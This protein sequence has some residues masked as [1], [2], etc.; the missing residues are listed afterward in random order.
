VLVSNVPFQFSHPHPHRVGYSTTAWDMKG[1]PQTAAV[2]QVQLGDFGPI[3]PLQP[4]WTRFPLDLA[5]AKRVRDHPAFGAPQPRLFL[6]LTIPHQPHNYAVFAW[7]GRRA[8]Q[9][10]RH[11]ASQIVASLQFQI[12]RITLTPEQAPVGALVS[13]Q[14]SGFLGDWRDLAREGGFGITLLDK[15]GDGCDTSI[16]AEFEAISRTR[17]HIDDGG[18][19]TGTF[20]VPAGGHCTAATPTSN[21]SPTVS[22]GSYSVLLGCYQCDF[23]RFSVSGGSG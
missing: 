9:A 5:D 2:V 20:T 16:G 17:L 7:F 11:L 6:P 8:S 13:V 14:G 15:T 1:L 10:D 22:P 18:N 3:G 19:L 23:A 4:P 21:Q 12:P